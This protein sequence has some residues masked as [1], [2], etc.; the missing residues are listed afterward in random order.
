MSSDNGDGNND[1]DL[2]WDDIKEV[3]LDVE[4]VL[5]GVQRYPSEAGQEW[6]KR[7]IN[8]GVSN[9]DRWP[10]AGVHAITMKMLIDGLGQQQLAASDLDD[11]VAKL[12]VFLGKSTDDLK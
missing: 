9:P 6:M 10:V 11:R 5:E 7:I 3:T 2:T 8:S 1:S 12:E 4:G